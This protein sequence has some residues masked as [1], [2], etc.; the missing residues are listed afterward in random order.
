MPVG[1]YDYIF[2]C[3]RSDK[4][5]AKLSFLANNNSTV[6]LRGFNMTKAKIDLSLLWYKSIKILFTGRYDE[7]KDKK[8]KTMD[9]IQELLISKKI[10]FSDKYFA[11]YNTNQWQ[12][13]FNNNKKLKNILKLI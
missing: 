5:F 6:V 3:S 7:F 10:K 11:L 8:V 12:N 4:L 9:Y 13:F 2:D 1:G